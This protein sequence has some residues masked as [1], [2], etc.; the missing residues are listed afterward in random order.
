MTERAA[1]PR[2]PLV[3]WLER[4]TRLQWVLAGIVVGVLVLWRILRVVAGVLLDRWWFDATTT[5][6]VWRVQN[7][8]RLELAAGALAITLAVLGTTVALVIG[9][10]RRTIAPPHRG[11]KWYHARMGPAH[12]WLL[13]TLGIYVT[14]QIT[15]TAPTL[16]QQWLLFLHGD[17]LGVHVPG[18]GGDL[19]TYLFSLP[20]RQACSQFVRQLLLFSLLVAVVGHGMSGALRFSRTVRS[21][22][23][24]TVHIAALIG[25]FLLAQAVHYVLVQRPSL[26]LDASGGF[27]GAGYT[28]LNV[29]APALWVAAIGALLAVGAL[30]Y[31]VVTRQWRL[32]A[33]AVGGFL[34][35]HLVALVLLPLAVERLVVAPAKGARQLPAIGH[36]LDATR[37]AY[38]LDTATSDTRTVNDGIGT[39]PTAAETDAVARTPLFDPATMA[40]SLQVLGGTQGTRISQVDLDR[41]P[42]DGVQRAMLVAARQPD[43]AGL[44]ESG[45]VQEHLVYTHGNGLVV[46]PAD[47]VD[48]DGRPNMSTTAGDAQHDPTTYFGE[49]L[50]GWWVIV[51]TQRQQQGGA[52]YDGSQGIPLGSTFRQA[53]TSLALGDAQVLLS[54]ELTDQSQL[55]YRRGL[56]DRLTTLAPFLSWD[57]DPYPAVVDGRVVWMVDGY[58]TSATYPYS[59]FYGSSGLPSSSDVGGTT[60]NYLRLAVR[61]TV[62]ATDGTTHLYRSES[63]GD[64]PII[65][66]WDHLFPGLLE[67]AD[68]M[69]AAVRAHLRYPKDLFV[70]QSTLLGQYHVA[71][72][73]SLFNGQ[74]RWTVSPAAA[75][76]VDDTSTSPSAPLFSFSTVQ[77]TTPTWSLTRTYNPGSSS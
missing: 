54:A 1:A 60:L 56:R 47:E 63:V 55:L 36:N 57:S 45:W 7:V 50:D 44:P 4:R 8:A 11:L 65:D 77:G 71:D 6:P 23:A 18:T 34:A 21:R 38:R 74:Q 2:F 19:G 9:I 75:S 22:R 39:A 16:W 72:A 64:D 67:P 14:W 13:V 52:Q 33:V 58:T 46:V 29:I 49:G 66:V 20:F 41:Y 53:V 3:A 32:P 31:G 26:A 27:V 28:Q 62:D 69:P 76:T 5:A 42:V 15:K 61:A 59:Q 40:A 10:G 30:A 25:A 70:V 35:L 17:Q 24:A 37:A 12:Q 68:G 73:E 43:R 48:A 51:G